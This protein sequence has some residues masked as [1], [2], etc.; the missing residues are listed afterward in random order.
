[1]G[2]GGMCLKQGKEWLWGYVK[3]THEEYEGRKEHESRSVPS[4]CKL[5]KNACVAAN[6]L[7]I[8][9]ISKAHLIST[10]N[11]C[12][13]DCPTTCLLPISVQVFAINQTCPCSHHQTNLSLLSHSLFLSLS[14]SAA[15]D[16][17]CKEWSVRFSK[18]FKQVQP[19]LKVTVHN[20]HKHS[21]WSRHT[22]E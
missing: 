9:L 2:G 12:Y 16:N 8:L 4:G 14:L 15:C 22:L 18:P 20:F 11:R 19:K 13:V 1:M 3:I 10:S 7:C 17:F 6:L 21:K 5:F